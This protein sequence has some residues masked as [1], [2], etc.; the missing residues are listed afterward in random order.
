MIR[1][2]FCQEEGSTER[3]VPSDSTRNGDTGIANLTRSEISR[4]RTDFLKVQNMEKHVS[5]LKGLYSELNQ[6][7]AKS[8]NNTEAVEG[9][10]SKLLVFSKGDCES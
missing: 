9:K 6:H 5:V 4:F 3:P 1:V 10:I 8:K 7:L 2:E